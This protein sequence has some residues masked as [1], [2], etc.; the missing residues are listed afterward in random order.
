MG[1]GVW[2]LQPVDAQGA[3]VARHHGRLQA[4][5]RLGRLKH[6]W[7]ILVALVSLWAGL[8]HRKPTMGQQEDSTGR[9]G[10]NSVQGGR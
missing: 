2:E 5:L 6:L 4:G 9:G 8:C 7:A 3:G 1:Q 10:C